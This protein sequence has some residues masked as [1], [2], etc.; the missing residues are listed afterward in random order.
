MASQNG[1]LATT[2]SLDQLGNGIS[3][4]MVD[5]LNK[6]RNQ[7]LGFRELGLDFLGICKIVSALRASLQEHFESN[8][9]FPERAI[10]ELTRV[11]TKTSE[12]F[13]LLQ[14]LLQKFTDYENGGTFAKLQKTW[15]LFFADKEIAKVSQSLKENRGALNMTMLLT[16]M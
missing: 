12:D 8:Q 5:F 7:P 3:L 1:L 13:T 4:T 10:P 2:Q 16:N 11:L 9:L 14:K 6:V 15:R